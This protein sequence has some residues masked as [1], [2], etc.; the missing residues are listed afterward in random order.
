MDH[1][2]YE[3]AQRAYE[4]REWRAAAEAFLSAAG[5]PGGP[6]NGEC[7]HLAGN[8]LMK[9][10]KYQHAVTVYQHALRDPDYPRTTIVLANLATAQAALGEYADAVATYGAALADEGYA[11]RYRLLQG[12]AGALHSMGRY[13]EAAGDYHAGGSDPANPD[14]GRALNN[15][16]LSLT[17]AGR[18]AE[19]IDAFKAAIA[20][21]TYDGKGKALAN[22]GLAYASL[23]RHSEA[24]AAFEASTEGFGHALSEPA[25]EAFEAATA[26]AGAGQ[27]R[28]TVEGRRTGEMPVAA[29][30]TSADAEEAVE[31]PVIADQEAVSEFFNRTD[32]EMRSLDREMRRKERAERR[33]AAD[34]WARAAAVALLVVMIV[35]GSAAFFFA[36]YGYPTQRQTV[37][38]MLDSYKAGRSVADFWVAA[39]AADVTKEM[40]TIPPKF[41]E[42]SIDRVDRSAFGSKV[43]I[44][45]KLEKGAPLRY[46]VSLSREGVGW[47]IVGIDNDWGTGSS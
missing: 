16:G 34:P 33:S 47:K 8:A 10:R 9:L 24:V 17:A 11:K 7:Y 42:A 30:P 43:E 29:M 41:S 35:G 45:V 4:A 12:R 22:L 15:L 21:A 13:A 37:A 6:G 18:P 5:G 23:G 25:R 26:A 19:A 38:G 32:E 28:E 3:E 27:A 14:P 39:P 44:T 1:A 20:C 31:I 46:R 2:R 36:G 40:A